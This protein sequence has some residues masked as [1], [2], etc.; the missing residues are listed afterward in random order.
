MSASFKHKLSAGIARLIADLGA[1]DVV[2]SPGSRSAPPA[3]AFMRNQDIAHHFV[4]DERSAGYVA[5]GIARMKGKPTITVCTSA[6]AV[7]N[8][9]PSL[10][11]AF[12]SQVPIIAITADRPAEW[13][14]QQENQAIFQHKV[15]DNNILASYS[16]DP[17]NDHQD[18]VWYAGRTINEA[19]SVASGASGFPGPVHINMP[20]REP[21][22]NEASKP[23]PSPVE[24]KR[25]HKAA[26]QDLEKGWSNPGFPLSRDEKVILACGQDC[27][28]PVPKDAIDQFIHQHNA[29]FLPDITS[30]HL[31]IEGGIRNYDLLLK[32]SGEDL[33][34][35]LQADTLITFGGA[36]VSKDFKEFIRNFPPKRHIHLSKASNLID[37]FQTLTHQIPLSP[38]AFFNSLND[39]HESSAEDKDQSY[40]EQ[41][42]LIAER[43][44]GGV[45]KANDEEAFT[46]L[47]IVD[48]ML[49]NLPEKS[50]MHLGNSLPVRLASWLGSLM[51]ASTE[52]HSNRGTSG[53]DGCLSTA[54]GSAKA[55]PERLHFLILG[56]MSFFYDRNGLWIKDLP[57]N[58][59][60]MVL[61]NNGGGIFR[62]L[63]GAEEQEEL[64]DYFVM[65]HNLNLGHTAAQH[66]IAY[67]K[68]TSP[69][70]LTPALNAF[71]RD[72][73]SCTLLEVIPD[74][75]QNV[76]G[77]KAF[78]DRIADKLAEKG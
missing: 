30:N 18:N 2:L 78:H 72:E 5:L 4:P 13:V 63:P 24:L 22:Y 46:E 29:V 77:I 53:I 73:A 17:E 41:W 65:P 28:E 15:F 43:I 58:L 33:K 54:C 51:P 67:L 35:T 8:Y 76:G 59:R 32:N 45:E 71:C 6:T 19:W 50:V 70:S 75:Q 20:F 55:D 25:V 27:K 69:E 38:E 49:R 31:H 3:L 66:N 1:E 39:H 48:T 7:L 64:E 47:R 40:K 36:F 12:F 74:Q 60:I 61:N 21:L 62:F 26:Y 11:E 9:G 10:A 16:L 23:E 52:V 14:A 44:K 57:N 37:T 42:R 34:A 68:A 56:D